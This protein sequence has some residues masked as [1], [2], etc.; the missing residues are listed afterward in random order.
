M[1]P[2]R[3]RSW[4]SQDPTTAAFQVPDDKLTDCGVPLLA[5]A[6]VSQTANSSAGRF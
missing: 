1:R 4:P 5:A 3:R 6:L 2:R